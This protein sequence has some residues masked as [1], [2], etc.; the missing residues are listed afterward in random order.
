M[1]NLDIKPLSVNE[2]WQGKRYKTPAYKQYENELLWLLPN[3]DLPPPPYKI[4]YI[5][6]FKNK[7][8][9]IDNPIKPFQDILCKKYGFDDKDIYEYS[10]KKMLDKSPKIEFQIKTI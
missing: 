3:I 9:D 6:T 10:V 2:A 5:F 7:S 4:S 1:I 8:S